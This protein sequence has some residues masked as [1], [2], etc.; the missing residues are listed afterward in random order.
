MGG[1]LFTNSTQPLVNQHKPCFYPGY[2]QTRPATEPLR[3]PYGAPSAFLQWKAVER[4]KKG[5]RGA[6]GGPK[7]L[8]RGGE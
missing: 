6:E 2:G 7:G 4:P 3:T 5:R 1:T 8:R